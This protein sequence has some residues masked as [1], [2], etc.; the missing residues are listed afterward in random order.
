MK[1]FG[2]GKPHKLCSKA[3]IDRLFAPRPLPGSSSALAY[4]LR[5]VWTEN[6]GRNCGATAQFLI[7]VPKKRLSHAV[8]RVTMRRRI[9]EAYRLNR[10]APEA[11]ANPVDMAFVYI[12]DTLEPY[13]KVEKSMQRL[14]RKIFPQP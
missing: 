4:P 11:T 8:D 14:L 7:S 13:A 12:A 6:P 2:L 9:R 3:A 10:P 5:A 1:R